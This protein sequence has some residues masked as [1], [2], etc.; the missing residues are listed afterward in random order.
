MVGAAD[1]GKLLQVIQALSDCE[2]ELKKKYDD[3]ALCV[4]CVSSF[5]IRVQSAI[6]A[7]IVRTPGA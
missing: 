1:E 4:D 3:A 6:I 7:V 2:R 5:R